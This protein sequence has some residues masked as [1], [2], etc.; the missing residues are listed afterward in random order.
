MR[1]IAVAILLLTG[2]CSGD[3]TSLR[4]AGTVQKVGQPE[5]QQPIP[6]FTG[7]VTRHPFFVRAFSESYGEFRLSEPYAQHFSNLEDLGDEILIS[8]VGRTETLGLFN[9]ISGKLTLA[10][11]G[12]LFEV[13]CRE[14]D[15]LAP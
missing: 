14:V 10:V 7:S 12:E 11:G 9:K 6:E 5:T 4:C 2:A 13:Q 15:R 1:N 3:T 8:E